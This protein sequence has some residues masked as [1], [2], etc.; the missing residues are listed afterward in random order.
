[1][2]RSLVFV[3]LLLFSRIVFSQTILPYKNPKLPVEE[4]VKDLIARMTPEEKF[5][6]LF[7][8]P[9]DLSDGKEKYKNGIFGFQVGARGNRDA[10]GQLLN[11]SA[12]FNAKETA[13]LIN[14]VQKYFVE[15][16][17]LG[18]PLICLYNG[19]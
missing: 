14:S 11:Y 17:R 2:K 4:R 19:S 10:A 12:A 9:G 13:K 15:D 5:W 1:M 16:T 18:I 6:Q 3:S 7:M 8:L